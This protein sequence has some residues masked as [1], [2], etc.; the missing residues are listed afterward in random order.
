[1]V[2]PGVLRFSSRSLSGPPHLGD[3]YLLAEHRSE[4]HWAFEF[5]KVCCSV[6]SATALGRLL[7][8][9]VT[10]A[11]PIFLSWQSIVGGASLWPPCSGSSRWIWECPLLWS[12]LASVRRT[13]EIGTWSKLKRTF[14]EQN[15]VLQNQP[16]FSR[17]KA[18]KR[19]ERLCFAAECGLGRLGHTETLGL[20]QPHEKNSSVLL[21]NVVSTPLGTHKHLRVHYFP[22]T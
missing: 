2:S 3:V 5:S 12:Q 10:A 20:E 15:L 9:L 13:L 1:M 22:R 6:S 17:F 4:T 7:G 14:Y 11:P 21:Q 19:K 8:G 16:Y 18:A